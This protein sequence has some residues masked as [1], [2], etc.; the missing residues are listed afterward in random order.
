MNESTPESAM[1]PPVPPRV[2]ATWPG[3]PEPTSVGVYT[4]PSHAGVQ[5]DHPDVCPKCGKPLEPKRDQNQRRDPDLAEMSRRFWIGGALTLPVLILVALHWIPD[6]GQG[7]WMDGNASRWFQ[8]LCTTPVVWWAGWPLFERGLRSLAVRK[9]D[10]FT[11]ISLGVGSTFLFSAA[12]MLAPGLFPYAMQENG[13]ID[14]YFQAAAMIVV[15]VLLGQVLELHARSCTGSAI[16]ALMASDVPSALQV[17]PGGDHLVPV[18]Q[19]KV[20]DWLRV[21]PGATVSVDGRV[22]EGSSTVDESMVTGEPLPLEKT[23]GDQVIGGTVNGTGTFVMRAERVGR[24]TMF[25]QIVEMVAQAQISNAPIQTLADRVSAFFVPVVLGVSGITFVLWMWF[26]PDPRIAHALVAAVTVLVIACP[27]A[28]GLATPLSILFAVRRASRDGVLVKNAKTLSDLSKVT[29]IALDMTGTLTSGKP[30]L[31]DILP[32]VGLDIDEFLRLAASLELASDHPLAAAIVQGAKNRG[33][34]LETATEFKATTSG[35]VCGTVAGR[36]VMVGK[37]AYLRS[38]KIEG[39]EPFE[40]WAVGLQENAKT[41]LFVAIDGRP[42]GI[43]S[44]VDTIKPTALE[45]IRE[46]RSLDLRIAMVTSDDPRTATAVARELG[47]DDIHAGLEPAGKVAL[48]KKWRAD[49]QRVA[50]AGDGLAD[51][52][53]LAEASVGISMGTGTDM[54]VPSASV[55][56][57]KGDLRRIAKAVRLGRATK[58]NI[59]EN[60][61]F[62]ILYNVLGIPLAAGALYPS[63]GIL[64]SPVVAGVA[65][66]LGSLSV[67]GNAL[68]LRTVKL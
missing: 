43:L 27:A 54:A 48:V 26:G 41:A 47:I 45:A 8:F 16:E 53:A 9:L 37:P 20:G 4:C 11:L 60:L 35:G 28:I 23:L 30:A 59:R 65:M 7:L 67:I 6:V 51:A 46:L 34:T 18:D 14:V 5:Q 63:F 2:R 58:W 33:I 66:T 10:M 57:V 24:D 21:V 61:F 25:A 50:M 52:S 55:T 36:S 29:T 22:L 44:T 19:V 3:P 49:G 31:V 39:L 15:L 1:I 13:R 40:A 62:A 12:A 56:L 38:E 64:L 32:A 17:A 68:R 42:A